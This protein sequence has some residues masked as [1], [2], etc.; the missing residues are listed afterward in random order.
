MPPPD[1]DMDDVAGCFEYYADPA[2]GLD[3]KQKAHVSLPMVTWKVAPALAAGCTA[4]LK[5]SELASVTCLELADV[6]R[7]VGLPPGVLNILTGLGT[8]VGA[9]LASHPH[10][11]KVAFTGSNATGSRIMAPADEWSSTQQQELQALLDSFSAIFGAPKT[12]PPMRDFDHLIPVVV[13]CKPP[14]IRPYTYGPLQ[15][16]E[17]E[18]CV[19]SCSS[20]EDFVKI[21]CR[22]FGSHGF[23]DYYE[24]YSR[25]D[26][27][28][29]L[30]RLRLPSMPV[31]SII[32]ISPSVVGI[33]CLCQCKSVFNT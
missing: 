7:E 1:E 31:N 4:I 23:E 18:K 28:I 30:L 19:S 20:W 25:L 10:V 13:G 22:D 29:L 8:E 21:F 6:F 16:S 17:I 9:P 15:K 14:S 27:L 33:I 26:S 2:E 24:R 12:L 3:A 5:P 32:V 11:D